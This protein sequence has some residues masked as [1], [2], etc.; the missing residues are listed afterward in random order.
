MC[1]KK[2]PPVGTGSMNVCAIILFICVFGV[3]LICNQIHT[4]AIRVIVKAW[5]MYWTAVFVKYCFFVVMVICIINHN[6]DLL[7]EK[8][9][10]NN[11]SLN[12]LQHNFH[13]I[14]VYSSYLSVFI[15]YFSHMS[16][17]FSCIHTLTR[18][19]LGDSYNLY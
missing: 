10:Q 16:Y 11:E 4:I 6:F 12:L 7:S 2:E 3:V 5:T 13:L 14:T 8:Y 15:V 9:V 1:K 18:P 19:P 17:D